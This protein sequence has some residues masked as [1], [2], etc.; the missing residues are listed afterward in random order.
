MAAPDRR[1]LLF[2]KPRITLL[3]AALILG[4]CAVA[5]RQPLAENHPASPVAAEGMTTARPTT[6]R[7]DETTRRSHAQ[8]ATAQKEQ[9]E[10]DAHGPVS[11]TPEE[12]TTNNS[13]QP[14]KKHEH[15]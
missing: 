5:P 12:A 7:A 11:G 6:L 15:H 1:D 2:M 13:A 10:W 8:L 9:E 3:S 4:G 14:E